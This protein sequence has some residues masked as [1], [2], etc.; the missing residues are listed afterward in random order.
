M[1]MN[2]FSLKII[3]SD[4]LFFDG[5]CNMLVVPAKD[6]EMAVMANHERMVVALNTGEIRFQIEDE[7]WIHAVIG[8]GFAEIGDNKTT[9]IVDTVE[10]PEEI[11]V[12]RAEE[13]KER[14]EEQ[15]RQKLSIQQYN[16]S[17]AS[18]ARAMSR[19]R[20]TKKL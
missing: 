9:I 10:Y 11:D 18:L 12:K 19:L 8:I 5:P 1:H 6:G 16:H 7:S 17:K 4:K 3:A 14:A 20:V 2:A 15:L 13:A